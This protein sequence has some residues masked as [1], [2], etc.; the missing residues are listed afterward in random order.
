MIR[1]ATLEDVPQIVGLIEELHDLSSMAP[2]DFS[3][4]KAKHG[5]IAFI[6]TDQFV[7]VIEEDRKCVGVFSGLVTPTWFGNDSLAI[8]LSW[9]V[10]PKYR[11]WQGVALVEQFIEWAKERG[12]KQIRPGVSTGNPA[13]CKI[14]KALGFSE[15][16]AGFYLD[17]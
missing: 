14:Y 9:Y 7:R 10:Q 17:V 6:S 13:A 2:L 4:I 3:P 8:D 12:V 11:D 16:G 15:A 5:L 1:N